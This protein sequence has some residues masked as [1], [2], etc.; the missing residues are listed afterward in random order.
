MTQPDFFTPISA[1]IIA[2]LKACQTFTAIVKPGNVIDM[3]LSAFEQFKG[4]VQAA[5]TPEVILLQ[6]SMRIVRSNSMTFDF[7]NRLLFVCTY[8]NLRTRDINQTKTAIV[9]ALIKAGVNDLGIQPPAGWPNKFVRGWRPLDGKDE[10]AG[11][12]ET[13]QWMRGTKRWI[14]FFGLE[15]NTFFD[16]KTLSSLP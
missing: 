10:L 15:V 3:S 9:V 5:D 11:A 8:D 4:T 6:D 2:A 12:P 1:G 14:G 7:Y 13:R 16:I